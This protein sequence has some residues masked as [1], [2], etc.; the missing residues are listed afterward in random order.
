MKAIVALIA[1]SAVV[2]LCASAKAES[3]DE[4]NACISDAFSVCSSEIPDRHAVYLC[5]WQNRHRLSQTCRTVMNNH[6]PPVAERH[7]FPPRERRIETTGSF[8]RGD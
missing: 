7:A 2:G 4:R 1:G 3:R 6:P 8:A 5:L